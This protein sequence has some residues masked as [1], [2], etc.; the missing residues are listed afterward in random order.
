MRCD[1][2]F[3]ESKTGLDLSPDF[4]GDVPRNAIH[5]GIQESPMLD[6]SLITVSE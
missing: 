4:R 6:V 2:G 1:H 5:G 3:K